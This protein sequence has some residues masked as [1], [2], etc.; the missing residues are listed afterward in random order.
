MSRTVDFF[1]KLSD[2]RERTTANRAVARIWLAAQ[3]PSLKNRRAAPLLVQ[4]E[5]IT[6]YAA[7]CN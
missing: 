1:T 6:L 5:L 7:C 2:Q 3:P 4:E